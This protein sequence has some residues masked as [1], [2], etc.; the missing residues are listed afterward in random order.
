MLI[1]YLYAAGGT[2]GFQRTRSSRIRSA[3]SGMPASSR[4][5]SLIQRRMI[6]TFSFGSASPASL[7]GMR[8]WLLLV[9]RLMMRLCSGL[10]ASQGSSLVPPLRSDSKVVMSSL[11]LRFLLSWQAGAV[12]L[13]DGGHVVDEADRAPGRLGAGRGRAAEQQQHGQ[14]Q[15]DE[16]A[17]DAVAAAGTQHGRQDSLQGWDSARRAGGVSPRRGYKRPAPQV[18]PG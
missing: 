18:S 8:V 16:R 5:P 1:G 9:I 7:G 10:P 13:R 4:A 3:F 15:A 11:P 14:G 12:F 6:S 2:G 17:E